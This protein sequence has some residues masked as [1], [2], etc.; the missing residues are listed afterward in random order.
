MAIG[1]PGKFPNSF[2]ILIICVFSFLIFVSLFSIFQFYSLS[3]F[4]FFEEATFISLIVSIAFQFSI[5]L[6][7]A[8]FIISFLLF[9]LDLFCSYF[10]IYLLC[11]G[12]DLGN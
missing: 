11:L 6:N 2:L 3:F 10:S 1:P 8:L 9:I 7:F 5:S 4:F 12:G